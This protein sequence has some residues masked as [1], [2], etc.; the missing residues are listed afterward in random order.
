METNYTKLNENINL[1]LTAFGKE[2]S[3][4]MKSF[5]Q[6]HGTMESQGALSPKIKELMAISIAVVTHCEECIAYH[7]NRAL[8]IGVN[9]LEIVDAIGVSV[10]MGGGSSLVY[11]SIAL[12]ALNDF[13]EK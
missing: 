1:L 7:I 4:I 8:K 3:D 2:A 12:K 9:R 10:I 11:A 13:E 5:M 6:L